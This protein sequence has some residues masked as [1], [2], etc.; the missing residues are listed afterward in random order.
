MNRSLQILITVAILGLL[1][2]SVI[3]TTYIGDLPPPPVEPTASHHQL[4]LEVANTP[5]LRAKGLR[6][7]APLAPDT[8]MLFIFDKPAVQ[9]MWNKDVKFPL[10]VIF[11]TDDWKEINAAQMEA[12]SEQPVC[13]AAPTKLAIE[14]SP[15]KEK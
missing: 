4:H 6:G 10:V 8:G 11:F 12:G 9:C 2:V 5:E 14:V 13:S 15:T 1:T 7:H 3:K